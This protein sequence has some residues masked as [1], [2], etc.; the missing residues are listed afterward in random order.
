MNRLF[1]IAS[2]LFINNSNA[3][4]DDIILADSFPEK[5]SEYEFFLDTKAQI[6]NDKVIPYEL[7]SSL[8]SVKKKS[9]FWL[10][11]FF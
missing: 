5:L 1:F 4:V 6:P 8:F 10:K 9:Y 7:I 3:V 2:L 11:I